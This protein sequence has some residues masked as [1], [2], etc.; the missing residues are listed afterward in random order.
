MKTHALAI[1][2]GA[3]TLVKGMMT[4]ELETKYREDLKLALESA[5]NILKAG[6][7]AVDAVEKAVIDLEDSPLFNAGKGS[8]FTAT[9]AHEM[10]ASIM[11]GK[12]LNAGAVTLIDSVKNPIRLARDIMDNSEHVFLAGEGAM[13]F[14]KL[15]QH[16]MESPDYFYDEFRHEQWLEIKDSDTFQ[17]DHS[18]KKDSK[19][20]TVGA[21]ALDIE[22]NL[23]AATSTG[24]MTNKRY[25]RIGDSPIIGSGTYANNKTCA[26][27]C[28]GNGEFFI[29]AVAAYDLACLIEHRGWTLEKA[30]NAVIHERIKKINGE[31]GL[32]AVDRQGHIAMPFNTEGMY[33]ASIDASGRQIIAIYK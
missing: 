22:G 25:G 18:V 33:R 23:A 6:G 17:L 2:G 28:T 26:V 31:G 24:G 5:Y 27:S 8:V 14:A 19:F 9:E 32:I 4:P 12:T 11:D 20:G 7:S 15:R 16:V 10:D 1:H 29:R 3:G 30:A 13:E 21:V